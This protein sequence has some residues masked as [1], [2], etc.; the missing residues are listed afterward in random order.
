M[1]VGAG[2]CVSIPAQIILIK[3]LLI[4]WVGE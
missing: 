4:K 3:F 1:I 2:E